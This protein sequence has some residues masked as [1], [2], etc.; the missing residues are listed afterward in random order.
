MALALLA[1]SIVGRFVCGGV[2]RRDFDDGM[3]IVLIS[4]LIKK[5]GKVNG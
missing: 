1:W 2:L 4:S 3:G 5:I